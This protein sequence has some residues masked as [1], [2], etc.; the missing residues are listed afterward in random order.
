MKKLSTLLFLC[1]AS[2]GAKA[3][4]KSL[5][6]IN[7]TG[8]SVYYTV[9]G[10][11][12]P[13]CAPAFSSNFISQAGTSTLYNSAAN[14]PGLPLTISDNINGAKVYT[15]L[16]ACGRFVTF[17]IGEPC[18]GLPASTNLDLFDA[19]CNLC[20]TVN[21]TAQWVPAN[22]AGLAYLIIY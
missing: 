5:R 22:S 1:A 7:N 2:L 12:A 13:S 17:N 9:L 6:V 3:Q 11:E 20:G 14:V 15:S 10:S 4:A 18:S 16:P 19:S 8:C 21:R